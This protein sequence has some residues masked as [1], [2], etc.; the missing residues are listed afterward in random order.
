[1]DSFLNDLNDEAQQEIEQLN[2]EIAELQDKINNHEKEAKELL[3]REARG[4][5]VFA[6]RVF[7]LKQGK[8]ALLT[9]IQHKKVR[10]NH[11]LVNPGS[12]EN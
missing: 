1:M 4:Q 6:A 12:R 3:E 7:E 9:E 2:Q 11:L 8:M 10:I 5:G